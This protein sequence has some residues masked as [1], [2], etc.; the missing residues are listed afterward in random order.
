M[1]RKA[2]LAGFFALTV[3]GG[4]VIGVLTAPGAWY[5]GLAK[6][7]FN[8]PPWVFAPVWTVLYVLI[9]AAGWRL[10]RAAP[11]SVAMALWWGQLALN[12]LWSPV[13]FA[14]H[15]IG[16]ALVVIVLLLAATLGV[17]AAAWRR[18]RPAALLFAPYALWVVFATLLNAALWRLN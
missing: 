1:T 6:P 8:P 4:L 13:F 5:A 18:D 10:W 11:G 14:A 15:R 17:I 2:A 7:A 12:F 3:G 16:L 9:G